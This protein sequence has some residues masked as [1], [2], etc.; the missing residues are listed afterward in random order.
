MRNPNSKL[1]AIAV[2]AAV[3]AEFNWSSAIAQVATN[4]IILCH[5]ETQVIKENKKAEFTVRAKVPSPPLVYQTLTYQWQK[6]GPGL[7]N[8]VN[9]YGATNAVFTIAHVTTNDVA[10]YRVDV[11]SSYYTNATTTSE[12]AQ[13]LVFTKNSPLTVYG[14]PV[15]STGSSSPNPCPGDYVGYV[16]YD[17]GSDWGWAG[18]HPWASTHK[19]TDKNSV[20]TKVEAFGSEDDLPCGSGFLLL[21][22]PGPPPGSGEDSKYQFTIYFP[23]GTSVPTI[24]YTITLSGFKP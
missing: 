4:P 22:H 6:R 24:P 15:V 13:L 11:T 14:S 3:L 1:V 19:A 20:S 9:I 16:T 10:Y 18:D 2:V 17:K 8:F 7:T 21:P 12:P 23:I 5:P